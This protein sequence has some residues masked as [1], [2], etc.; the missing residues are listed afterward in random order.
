MAHTKAI[1]NE[2]CM[3]V[4]T[5]V[6][7]RP[8][9]QLTVLY[10]NATDFAAATHALLRAS[11]LNLAYS[12]LRKRILYIQPSFKFSKFLG[13]ANLEFITVLYKRHIITRTLT[14]TRDFYPGLSGW[15]MWT[16]QKPRHPYRHLSD[17]YCDVA[18]A[19]SP[20]LCPARVSQ[21]RVAISGEH[22]SQ[23]TRTRESHIC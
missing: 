10:S 5:R 22:I 7:K 6:Q 8:N 4:G 2:S 15:F 12:N 21:A 1:I 14:A 16:F 11:I 9:T 17:C 23:P 3:H 19:P 18:G 13:N 20:V